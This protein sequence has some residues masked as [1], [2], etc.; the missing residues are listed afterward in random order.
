MNTKK[1]FR[2]YYSENGDRQARV[3]QEKDWIQVDFFYVKSGKPEF[4]RSVDCSD[5]SIWWAEDVAENWLNRVI[6]E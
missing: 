1:W 3:M 2:D 5:H 4:V 6:P